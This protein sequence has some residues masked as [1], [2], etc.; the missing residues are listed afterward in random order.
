MQGGLKWKKFGSVDHTVTAIAA[1]N[2][3]LFATNGNGEILS[4]D[5]A[6]ST[7]EWLKSEAVNNI[8]SLAAN[9]RKLFALTIEGV[10]YQYEPG[11]KD[12]KWLKA[13]Y[14]NGQTIKEEIKHITVLNS[15]LFGI[16][17]ENNL[18]L[19]EHRTKGNLTAREV[20]IKSN[21]NSVVIIYK[22]NQTK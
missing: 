3:I 10:L 4:T 2:N 21:E 11:R 15:R 9:N 20:A 5:L 19:G 8:V 14:K 18:Y 1:L 12:S 13:A 22:I 7:I 16:S 17:K 6:K